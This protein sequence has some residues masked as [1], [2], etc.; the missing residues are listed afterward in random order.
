MDHDAVCARAALLALR[1]VMPLSGEALGKPL[2]LLP[3]GGL[4][5]SERAIALLS[6]ARKPVVCVSQLSQGTLVVGFW[7][8]DARD[9][10]EWHQDTLAEINRIL[11]RAGEQAV[12]QIHGA[13]ES[14]DLNVPQARSW[15]QD[16]QF[17]L[18]T[19][20]IEHLPATLSGGTVV[21][22]SI[23]ELGPGWLNSS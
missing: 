5:S 1:A 16:Y 12:V 15:F 23:E 20:R 22:V 21:R 10:S 17:P 3:G 18:A 9:V 8:L 11:D 2:L 4:H 14:C 13:N 7:S 6:A 19:Q